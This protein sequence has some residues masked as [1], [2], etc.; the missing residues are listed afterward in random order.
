MA[1][2]GV[3][4]GEAPGARGVAGGEVGR[5]TSFVVGASEAAAM[6]GLER[7]GGAEDRVVGVAT[8][9][10]LGEF[11]GT[12]SLLITFSAISTLE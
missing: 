4:D 1:G 10:L 3:A 9:E 7:T 11:K 5:T 6:V 12:G 8:E 2:V